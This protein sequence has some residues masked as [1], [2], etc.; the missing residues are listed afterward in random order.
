MRSSLEE[1]VRARVRDDSL[2]PY[3]APQPIELGFEAPP[4]LACGADTK[5]AFCVTKGRRAFLSDEV[6]ELASPESIEA[7]DEGIRH[8]LRVLDVSPVCIAHDAH[9]DYLSTRYA[10]SFPVGRKVAVQHHHAH[11]ASCLAEHRLDGTAIGVAFDGTGLGTDGAIWGGEFLVCGLAGFDRA[12]HLAYVP[13]PGGDA[14]VKEPWRMA[15]AYLWQLLG[16]GMLTSELAPEHI[17]AKPL[18]FLI[19]AMR[20]GV[21]APMTSSM[22][23]LFDAVSALLGICEKASYE[24]EPAILLERAASSPMTTAYPFELKRHCRPIQIDVRGMIEAILQDR[25]RG[26]PVGVIAGQFHSTLARMVEDV[27]RLLR[28]RTGIGEVALSG[29][30]FQNRL[31]LG[32]ATN[33]LRQSGFEVLI[34]SAVPS[35]D[36]GIA[37]GQAAV[38]SRKLTAE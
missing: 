29:G 22:G 17:K 36:G 20:R 34:H 27:C 16:D 19:Q 37:L 25:R 3:N 31:L 23:R 24:G 5:N 12:A 35:N 21:N 2:V 18:D 1:T 32:E 26:A 11:I 6:G 4:V 9:P 28:E 13:L 7:L 33:R 38:A 10:L 14:A 8:S 15:L 30:V